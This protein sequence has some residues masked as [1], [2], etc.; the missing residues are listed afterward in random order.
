MLAALHMDSLARED[1]VRDLKEC[2]QRLPEDL[3]RTYDD[4]LKR[5]NLQDRKKQARADQVLKLINCAR[6]PLKTEE[7]RQ[8]LSIR[9]GDNFLDPQALPKI[10]ALISSCCG[11]VIVE[12]ES[13]VVRLVH[14][15]TKEYF[16]HKVQR[17]FSPKAHQYFAEILITYLRFDAFTTPLG[18]VIEGAR[19]EEVRAARVRNA[20]DHADINEG[21]IIHHYT[22][23]L[24]ESNV[25][26]QYAAENWGHHAQGAFTRCGDNSASCLTTT[27]FHHSNADNLWNLKQLI[28]DFLSHERNVAWANE[29]FYHIADQHVG[30]VILHDAP[31]DVTNLQIAASFG[32]Q[33]LVKEC[34]SQRGEIDARDSRGMTALHQAAKYGH[35]EVVGLL[36][37]AGA[38]IE[39]RDRTGFNALMWAVDMNEVS[40]SRLLLQNKSDTTYKSSVRK[41]SAIELAAEKG[42]EEIVE[43]L[44]EFETDDLKRNE[45]M[46]NA[47]I[48]AA[49]FSQKGV[50]RFLMRGGTRWSISEDRT[51]EAMIIASEGD[52]VAMMKIL[53]EAGV[54]VASPS[55]IGMNSLQSAV[56]YGNLEAIKLLLTAGV[57][58]NE[59]RQ[60]FDTA[61]VTV[62]KARFEHESLPYEYK[63]EYEYTPKDPVP[64]TQKLLEY[65]ADAAATDRRFNRT[66]LEWAVLDGHVDMVQLLLQHG[67]FSAIRQR[68]MLYLAEVYFAIRE[69][70]D[71]VVNRLLLDGML[72]EMEDLS[73]LLL[74]HIPAERGYRDVVQMFLQLGADIEATTYG[75]RTALHLAARM[76]HVGVVKHLV[77]QAAKV[78]SKDYDGITPLMM[79]ARRGNADVVSF[80]LKKGAEIDAYG[81]V[82]YTEGPSSAIGQAVSKEHTAIVRL[83]LEKGADPNS[84]FRKGTLLHTAIRN[85]DS[86]SI[87]ELLLEKGADLEAKNH[88]GQ[89]V[90]LVAAVRA[91]VEIVQLLLEKGANLEAKDGNGRTAL[92]RAARWYGA[93]SR[94]VQLLLEKGAELEA[95]DNSGCTALIT[96]AAGGGMELCNFCL[97]KVPNWKQRITMVRLP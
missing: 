89:T 3:D 64:I 79:A 43:L 48:C 32:I 71:E 66:P 14:Y 91:E 74:V 60:G 59:T 52:D 38:G 87:V 8:A 63:Y 67:S 28:Q 7:L 46:G 90:L 35:L 96:A 56:E 81:T 86:Q 1:N 57:N 61:I 16:E 47:L 70:D 11:L 80:L 39:V 23:S 37:E 85:G 94:T 92:L 9:Q 12:N 26:L 62:A 5:I 44:A 18:K 68:Q 6:R 76:G 51:A 69:S 75:E 50:V 4:A 15:T 30:G 77:H 20:W 10:E 36:L 78:N 42:Y 83:L 82:E 73:K 21:S 25:S 58:P 97:R 33:Y 41:S 54:D 95:K 65:G 49:L 22:E 13:Q 2:L 29:V 27:G 19:N 40:V 17:Y 53:L 34:L 24:I 84:K 72:E 55:L 31:S 88:N 93:H 45:A